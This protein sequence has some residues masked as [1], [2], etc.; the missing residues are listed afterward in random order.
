MWIFGKGKKKSKPRIF[1]G[2]DKSAYLTARKKGKTREEKKEI[3]Y[4]E[5]AKNEE[6]R[7]SLFK[8]IKKSNSSIKKIGVKQKLATSQT[9]KKGF[10]RSRGQKL[11]LSRKNAI[12]RKINSH[13]GAK[14]VFLVCKNIVDF[15]LRFDG[16]TMNDIEKMVLRTTISF[17]ATEVV[18]RF[19]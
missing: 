10:T 14:E 7:L 16:K 6:K 13:R 19:F 5:K 2:T 15:A 4:L 3:Y 9:T 17:I 12:L 11:S 8:P 1:K 18:N